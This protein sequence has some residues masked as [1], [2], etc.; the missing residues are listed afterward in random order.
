MHDGLKVKQAELVS[1]SFNQRPRNTFHLKAGDRR[2]MLLVSKACGSIC[3][4]HVGTILGL[5]VKWLNNRGLCFPDLH[6]QT[7]RLL[8]TSEVEGSEHEIVS[9]Q[10]RPDQVDNLPAHMNEQIEHS[11][12]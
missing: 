3:S 9:S 5:L 1:T 8:Y 7:R 11:L 2:G 12:I 6:F 4:K 10:H